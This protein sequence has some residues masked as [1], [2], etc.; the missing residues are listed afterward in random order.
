MALKGRPLP[1]VFTVDRFLIS[2]EEIERAF[3]EKEVSERLHQARDQ[4]ELIL[5]QEK[6]SGQKRVNV[7]PFIERLRV[8][9]RA[10]YRLDYRMEENVPSINDFFKADFL[11]EMDIKKAG[12]VRPA[13]IIQL[14]LGLT[15]EETE[16]L[17]VVKVESLPPLA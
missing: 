13:A 9:K 14:I 8:M 6:K 5:I 1:T 10:D 11:I 15:Q 4:G 2:L 3:S 12:G 16:L 17:R 7:L